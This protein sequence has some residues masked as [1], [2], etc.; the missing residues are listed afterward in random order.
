M[1]T[2][3]IITLI[4]AILAFIASLAAIYNTNFKRFTSER[5]YDRQLELLGKLYKCLYEVQAYSQLMTKSVKLAGEE[6]DEYPRQLKQALKEAN[7]E[8]VRGRLFL[9]DDVAQQV[10]TFFQKIPEMQTALY[11]ATNPKVSDGPE[12][13]K[14]WEEAGTIAYKE[15]PALL[16]TI[17]DGAGKILRVNTMSKCGWWSLPIRMCV[18]LLGRHG[19]HT[20]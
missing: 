18:H 9:P 5:I 8:F 15:M 11:M 6:T 14:F 17:A 12:R 2:G 19:D 20:S 3:D 4:A 10:D 16:R 13:A 1:S 7:D